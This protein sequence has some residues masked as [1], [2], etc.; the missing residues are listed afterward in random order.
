M[1]I[2]AANWSRRVQITEIATSP[3]L[4]G[5]VALLTESNLP[6][7]IWTTAI[8][9]GGDL[10]VCLN[11]DGSSQLPLEVV[12]FDTVG[13][14]AVLW[15]RFPTFTSGDSLWLFYGKAGET[16]PPVTDTHGRNA[17]WVDYDSLFIGSDLTIDRTG[18]GNDST[19]SSGTITYASDGLPYGLFDGASHLDIPAIGV[20]STGTVKA[21][22][23]VDEQLNTD[24]Y[25]LSHGDFAN[26]GRLYLAVNSSEQIFTRAGSGSNNTGSTDLK[27]TSPST[28][29]GAITGG[30]ITTYANGSVEVGSSTYTGTAGSSSITSTG[31]GAFSNGVINSYFKGKIYIVG[32]KTSLDSADFLL[33]EYANQ[34]SPN[35]FWSTG[36]PEDVGVV[37]DYYLKFD[38][39]NDYVLVDINSVSLTPSWS[40]EFLPDLTSS[41]ITTGFYRLFGGSNNFDSDN[42][43]IS[44]PNGND[45]RFSIKGV[46]YQW[47]NQGIDH[48]LP[49]KL[50]ATPSGGI[51][52]F[53]DGISKGIRG[54][55]GNI[56]IG[57]GRIGVNFNTYYDGG[58]KY[59]DFQNFNDSS[60][61]RYY[62]PS[63]TN[64]I[65]SILP[66][67]EGGNNGTLVNFPTDDSQWVFY[68][69]GGGGLVI[70]SVA[71]ASAESFG[72][73]VLTA[74]AVTLSP[75]TIASAEALGSPTISQQV[76]ITPLSI[77][78]EEFV[79]NP[80]VTPQGVII[81]PVEIPT[82]ALV[83]NPEVSVGLAFILPE[84]I[85]TQEFVGEPDI[86]LILKQI[87]PDAIAS[88][89]SVGRPL[90]LGGDRIIIPIESRVTWNAV[91]KYLRELVFTGADNDVIMKWL[92][93]E[94]F[95]D[96]YND[97]WEQYLKSAGFLSGAMSDK[98]ALWRQGIN[99]V[100]PWIL[101][102][103]TWDDSK[104]WQ[105]LETW[106]DS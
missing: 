43:I 27:L 25:V 41:V 5:Y 92:R 104:I 57:L 82:E 60:L 34:S 40:L 69:A 33:T 36:T 67:T 51:E 71:I 15:V 105:D 66:D 10:R 77:N 59:V 35:T 93:S 54:T 52:L 22:I 21:T 96:A 23:E 75:E 18:N 37:G 50:V 55:G 73:P 20:I 65:G 83:G 56:G 62:D 1:T 101:S 44:S 47:A 4:S 100:D 38:G 88:L 19:G 91:A 95:D 99:G 13:E 103:G 6:A 32:V 14:T 16:Q 64:G 8:N 94:G 106:R 85:A 2:V 84:E 78:T 81:T 63:A 42:R 79:G 48:T 28:I 61:N 24:N 49:I 102:D 7:E 17:V 46:Q 72:T 80:I 26:A 9:G 30:A 68:D 90:V 70:T 87:F 45:F 97:N 53:N 98:Y 12:S 29:A 74:G 3:A 31:I 89:L 86:D 76:Q 58:I 11:S 39:V